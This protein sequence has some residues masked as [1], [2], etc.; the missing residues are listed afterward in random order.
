MTYLY[1][2]TKTS[3]IILQ[4]ICQLQ[5]SAFQ[6]YL[7]RARVAI[8]AQNNMAVHKNILLILW[9][10]WTDPAISIVPCPSPNSQCDCEYSGKGYVYCRGA[11][12]LPIQLPSNVTFLDLDSNRV[13]SILLKEQVR[14]MQYQAISR[15]YVLYKYVAIIQKMFILPVII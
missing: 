12:S 1:I 2:I 8:L 4:M 9:I 10:Y 7:G 15:F 3:S 6:L 11:T 13:G 5:T 14:I